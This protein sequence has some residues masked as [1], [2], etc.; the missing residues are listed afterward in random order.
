MKRLY[1]LI[2][3]F[4]CLVNLS[5][6]Q[7]LTDSNLPIVIIST[8]GGIEIPDNPR[9]LANMKIIY[10]GAGIRNFVSDMDSA[11]LLNYSG[12]IDIEIRGSST[13]VLPKKQYGFT[14][15][16][17]DN[18]SGNNVSLLGLPFESDWIFN[19]LGFDPS[20]MR[21]Y[22]SYNLSRMIGE[23]AT[24]TVYCELIINGSYNGLYLL[25][26]KMKAGNDRI[27]VLKIGTGDNTFPNVTG[28]YITKTDKLNDGD[29][30]AWYASSYLAPNDVGYI[31]E[32]PKPANVT[33]EQNNYIKSEFDKLDAAVTGSNISADNGYPSIIDIPSFLNFIIVNELAA[34]VDAYQYSTYYHKDRNGKLRAGPIW[35]FNL[36]YGNDLFM[37]GFDR[38]KTD[39]WQFSNGDNEGPRYWRDLFNNPQFRCYLSKRWNEL[40]Q[41]GQPLNLQSLETFINQTV[42]TISEATVRE[43][44]RWGTVGNHTYEINKIKTFLQQ[45]ITW[46]TSHI[47]L[48]ASCSNLIM[49]SLV[50]TRIMYNPGTSVDFPNS[51]DLEFVEIKNIGSTR[52]N[53]TGVYFS[54][55]GFVYQFPANT[56]IMPNG[57][58]IL[59]SNSIVFKAKY[60]S[61]ASGQFT[62]NLSNT[63]QELVLSDA[64]GNVI[65]HVRYSNQ[66]PWPSADGNGYFLELTDPVSDNNVAANWFAMTGIVVSVE[67]T[68]YE[69][70][71]KLYP[72]PV[73]DILTVESNSKIIKLQI[74]DFQGLLLQSTYPYSERAGIDMSR[75]S[76][77][78]FFIKAVTNTGSMVRK[79][80]KE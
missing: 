51:N 44:A 63:G 66:S 68:E 43:E 4:L 27:N 50:I 76:T 75:Y 1:I 74:F 33:T 22:L 31:H 9:V 62:R 6:S 47:G 53:L 40:I 28:G 8:D 10:R 45:R 2:Y 26:E 37:W 17:A 21:D 70:S 61:N 5:F 59:A 30:I 57:T 39:T 80:V 32:L 15:R 49:P 14:T 55:T 67:D 73:T 52:I 64:F 72:L 3:F 69:G 36:T 54:G 77:G 56:L 42:A 71:L 12:R 18:I 48:Y 19:G 38:S 65:D 7:T 24:R 79:V 46:I 16:K 13:Q 78:I 11:Y 60:G 34:N 58:K 25:Q 20:L 35:D 41:P 23:Y 29:P